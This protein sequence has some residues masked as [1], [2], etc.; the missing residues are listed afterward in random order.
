MPSTKFSSRI[1]ALDHT[2][3]SR[4]NAIGSAFRTMIGATVNRTRVDSRLPIKNSPHGRNFAIGDGVAPRL[5]SALKNGR[6]IAPGSSGDFRKTNKRQ[7]RRTPPL[8]DAC[9]VHVFGFFSARLSQNFRVSQL[10]YRS[11]TPTSLR[12]D[13]RD[14]TQR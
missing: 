11:K 3:A 7:T 10:A 14:I 12:D 8:E 13:F 1:Q 6:P 9:C 2:L 5:E 4:M